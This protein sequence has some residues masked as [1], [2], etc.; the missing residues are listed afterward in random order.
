MIE[1][2]L[3][4]A[5]V[6]LTGVKIEQRL[7]GW[8]SEQAVQDGRVRKHEEVLLTP[9]E[10]E[11][12]ALEISLAKDLERALAVRVGGRQFTHFAKAAAKLGRDAR[13]FTPQQATRARYQERLVEARALEFL[14]VARPGDDHSL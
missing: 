10:L 6:A 14:H 12:D 3:V 8:A 1:L 5:R 4:A 9:L 11:C 7:G 13:G 2:T